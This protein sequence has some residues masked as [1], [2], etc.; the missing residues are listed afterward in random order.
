MKIL[1]ATDGS[2]YSEGAAKFLT[3]FKLTKDDEISILHVMNWVP[4]MTEWETLYTDFREIREEIA[5]R[6]LASAENI[7]KKTGAR[8]ST[9]SIEGYPGKEISEAGSG[10]DLVVMGATGLR[11][12]GSMI[13]GSVTKE[14]AIKSHKPVLAIKPPQ[15]ETSGKL[16]VLFATDGS[17]FSD[18]MTRTLSSI[19]FPDNTEVTVLHVITS[20]LSDIPERFAIEMN[21]RIKAIV[22][23]EREKESGESEKNLEKAVKGLSGK[24]P[25]IKK[26]SMFGDP[27]EEIINAA[28]TMNADII[29]LGSSG[30]RGIKGMLGSVSRYVLSHCKCSV[31]IGKT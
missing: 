16:K 5:P 8:T 14:V 22:A 11:G 25:S 30:M 17:P 21:D 29:A 3:G 20:V 6:V 7:L 18:A 1:F 15:W 27:S 19:P 13:V 28:E 31:L 12:I 4:V 10:S 23:K 2:E 24:F 26:R 9:S